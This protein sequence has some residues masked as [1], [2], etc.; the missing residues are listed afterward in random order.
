MPR[1]SL[2]VMQIKFI[3]FIWTRKAPCMLVLAFTSWYSKTKSMLWC[4]WRGV[5]EVVWRGANCL[6]SAI[7]RDLGSVQPSP[8]NLETW[9]AYSLQHH[10][11]PRLCKTWPGTCFLLAIMSCS[12]NEPPKYVDCSTLI[13][14]STWCAFYIHWVHKIVPRKN[15]LILRYAL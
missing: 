15:M 8:H 3:W 5:V 6:L 4:G 10:H 13:D 14:A 1:S 12:D 11:Q 7:C 2:Q 9:W